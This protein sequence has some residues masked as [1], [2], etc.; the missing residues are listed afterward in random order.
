[1]IFKNLKFK[2]KILL[3]FFLVFII[4]FA[5]GSP[6]AYLQL[7]KTLQFNI[8]NELQN[9]TDSVVN[10]IESAAYVSIKNRL[11]TIAEKNLDIAQYYYSKYRSGLLTRSEAI[12][13]I[14]EVFLNQS[15]GISGYIYCLNGKGVLTVH[16]KDKMKGSDVSNIDFVQ[17]QLEVKD[18]YME[19]EWKN[20]GE[21]QKKPKVLYMVYYKSLDW[22]ISVSAYREE[23]N[24][25]VDINDFRES[26]LTYKT[27]QTGYAYVLDEQGTA[28]IH[29]K[30][31]GINLL[32]QS[33]QPNGFLKQ[34]LKEKNGRV[35]YEWKNPDELK[36]RK[37][38]A[39]F[40]H[41]P[42]YQWIVVSS[43]YVDEVFSPLITF[44]FLLIVSLIVIFLVSI[45]ITYLIIMSVTKPL[46]SL[47]DKFGKGA[48]G[49]FSTRMEI[50]ALDE[51]GKLAQHFNS[52]MDQLEK[53]DKEIKAEIQKNK[54]AQAALVENDLKLRGIFNQSY[55]YASVLSPA[56]NLEELNRAGFELAGKRIKDIIGQPFWQIP[57]WRHDPDVQQLLK[58]SVIKAGNG[59]FHRFEITGISKDD[60]IRDIDLSIK[61]LLNNSG[62][63]ISIIAEARDITEHNKAALERKNMAV[64]L[65]KSQKMEAIGT[66]AGGIAH[67]FNNILSGI[68]GH[69]QLTEINLDN[70][71]KAKGHIAQIN[72][73]AQRAAALI[74]QILTFSRQTDNEKQILTLYHVVKEALKLL[75][76]LIPTTIEINENIVSKAKIMADPTQMHQ[77]IM[78]LCTNAYHAMGESGGVLSIQLLE[79]EISQEKDILDCGIINGKYL[80]LE[81][82]DTGIGMDEKTMLKAFDPYF[83]TKEMGKGTG[84]GLALVDTIVK[85][86]D[87][88][89]KA[90]STPG[91][92]T[93]FYIFLPIIEQEKD[94]QLPG[95]E[96]KIVK[97][98]TEKIMVVDD[99]K[100]L[101]LVVQEFLQ[102]YGY[103]VTAFENGVKAFEA[104][105][106]DLE[107]FDLIITDMAMPGGMTGMEFSKNVL[108]LRQ[109]MPIILCTGYSEKF[110]EQDV[111]SLGVQKYIQKP[112]SNNELAGFIREILD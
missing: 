10:F 95:Q 110:S 66:L 69:S 80:K 81:I 30:L 105:E 7:K 17:Y 4:L 42:Q 45:G 6:I 31:E 36:I 84:L 21:S 108:Q 25:L 85:E 73:G 74:Q 9:T 88:F 76:S 49:D 104:F 68:L 109:E 101:R 48:R 18:G 14:E 41:L 71:E 60:E 34:I 112:I 54:E 5:I 23:F 13:I 39:I 75:G 107:Y 35:E 57:W 24:Y 58:E 43:S 12:K 100:D 90:E 52:F 63:V 111:I 26:I 70:F 94:Y 19:Y 1:M 56:G 53:N 38:I 44:R 97:G 32:H 46:E 59:E 98:G 99:E 20:P 22:I 82:S 103:Q 102:D 92:G 65:E 96:Q 78:N 89:I 15:I 16:P 55:Q 77:I 62:E 91:K 61:P 29:P 11:R 51:F 3:T 87:G 47:M 72:K 86:H 67:D 93:S 83:T 27:G 2:N 40:K 28:V 37:K 64:Q 8:D 106:Q 33:K 50:G 79:V